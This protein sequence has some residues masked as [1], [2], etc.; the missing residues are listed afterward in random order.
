MGQFIRAGSACELGLLRRFPRRL[1]DRAADARRIIDALAKL[2]T[3]PPPSA[4]AVPGLL[5]GVERIEGLLDQQ[6]AAS[7]AAAPVAVPA[8]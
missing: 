1:P 2:P 5:S 6:L 4:R 7:T 8:G 3:L